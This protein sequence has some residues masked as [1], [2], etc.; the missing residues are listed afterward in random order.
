MGFHV[1]R[2]HAD[3]MHRVTETAGFALPLLLS[4]SPIWIPLAVSAVLALLAVQPWHLH[5]TVALFA[6]A[7][8]AVQRHYGEAAI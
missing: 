4:L 3:K 6:D 8:H 5:R 1:G 2:R 7:K